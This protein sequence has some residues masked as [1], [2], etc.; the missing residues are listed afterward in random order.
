MQV[1]AGTEAPALEVKPATTTAASSPAQEVANP[2][3]GPKAAGGVS[4]PA[5][6]K[7]HIVLPEP[8]PRPQAAGGR[9]GGSPGSHAASHGKAPPRSGTVSLL[10][11][12]CAYVCAR[13]PLCMTVMTR[14][15]TAVD[16]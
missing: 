8:S 1:I 14:D 15:M 9:G 3:A 4:S 2:L 10:Q 7:V 13:L 6:R 12:V 11:A 5:K 16:I